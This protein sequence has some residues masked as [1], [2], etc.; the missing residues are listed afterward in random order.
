LPLFYAVYLISHSS[1]FKIAFCNGLDLP[2]YPADLDRLVLLEP[3]ERIG[4]R[5]DLGHAPAG[6]PADLV[7]APAEYLPFADAS[8]DT[9]VSTLVLCTVSDPRRAVA[10][11]AR[12]LRPGGRLLFLEHVRADQ[13]W[14]RS[15]QQRSARPWA[16]FADGCRCDRE[17]LATI[18]AQM[19]IEAI[20]HGAW[21]GMPDGRQAAGP[22]KRDALARRR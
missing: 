10:E 11:V 1:H 3:G 14:R 19:R 16:G 22:G 20:E 21:R 6:V 2:H 7:R 5:I 4:G 17:T 13:G 18:E 12:V 8:F 9:V 15:L